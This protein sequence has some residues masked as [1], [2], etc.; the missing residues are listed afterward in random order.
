[1]PRPVTRSPSPWSATVRA[2]GREQGPQ[3][4]GAWAAD[5]HRFPVDQ[6]VQRRVGQQ[7][8]AVDDQQVVGGDGHLAH[9][10][11]GHQDRATVRGQPFEQRT[12]PQHAVRVEAVDRLVQQH[13]GRVAE[14]RRR[15]AQSLRHAEREPADPAP[16]GAGQADLVEQLVGPAGRDA[17]G[18]G[19]GDQVVARGPARMRG[20]GVEQRA[21][22][23][24]RC[25][26]LTIGT[27]GDGRAAG[28]GPVEGQDHPHRRRLPGAVRPQEPG[29]LAGPHG[30]RESVHG[31]EPTVHFGQFGHFDHGSD[32]RRA[33]T[34]PRRSQVAPLLARHAT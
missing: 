11:A 9:Q 6:R 2:V 3:P 31:A 21:H 17:V 1:M 22:R 10:V 8:P 5:E 12:H 26:V 27:A 28:G 25:A 7:P 20:A 14:Q 4:V 15:D 16:R 18:L 24:Q 32:A 34:R 30:E 13:H 19:E 33:G 23:V 29:Y